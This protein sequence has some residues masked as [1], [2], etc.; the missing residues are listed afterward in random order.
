MNDVYYIIRDLIGGGIWC[1]Y[2]QRFRGINYA[3]KI[4][5][6][7]ELAL[8]GEFEAARKASHRGV[9]LVTVYN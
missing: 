4:E 9:E 7:T 5:L 2:E 6:D 3:Y 1:S 8:N